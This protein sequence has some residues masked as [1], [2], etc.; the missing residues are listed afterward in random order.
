M[1]M[2]WLAYVTTCP[3]K[4]PTLAAASASLDAAGW[5]GHTL[6]HDETMSG[7][8]NNLLRALD[9]AR[10]RG[11]WDRLLV[12]QDDAVFAHGVREWLEHQYS[13]GLLP[14][15]LVSL[16]LPLTHQ[17]RGNRGWWRLPDEDLP[18][19]AYG[20]L[21]YVFDPTLVD[22]V[23]AVGNYNGQPNKAEF[24]IGK[25]CLEQNM[26]YWYYERSFCQHIGR[27]STISPGIPWL[28]EFRYAASDWDT[29]I[30]YNPV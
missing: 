8:R 18:R 25:V 7:A 14:S 27:H 17:A 11:E 28:K 1:K 22:A 15:G 26:G 19:K 24:L 4:Q 23:L 16:W 13:L 21:A 3:R 12:A 30:N 29:P 10:R 2:K 9:Q 20:A 6:L 5:P